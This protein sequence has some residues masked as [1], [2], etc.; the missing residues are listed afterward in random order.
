[1]PDNTLPSDRSAA[2]AVAAVVVGEAPNLFA[3]PPV[4]GPRLRRWSNIGR[5][6]ALVV[7]MLLIIGGAWLLAKP[8]KAWFVGD[9]QAKI[10]TQRVSRSDLVITVLEDGNIESASNVDIKCEVAGGSVILSI[11]PDGTLVA[12]GDK[13]VE[14]DSSTIEDQI[15]Q[16]KIVF[17]KAVAARI[18]VEK[19]L[20]AAKIAVQEYIEGT[21]VKEHQAVEAQIKIALE[22]MRSSENSLQH[23]QRLARKGYV[24]PLQLEAQRFAVDRAKLDL[25]TAQT[26]KTVLEKFTKAKMLEDLQS[27][28]D[29]AE[30]RWRAEQAAC[31]LEEQR[32]KRFQTQ[33]EKCVILA[34][35]DGMVIYANEMSGSRGSSSSQARIEEG[36]PVRERQSIIRLPDLSQMQVKVLVH[37]SKVEQLAPGQ[38]AQVKLLD[39]TFQGAVRNV[40]NQPEPSSFFSSNVKEYAAY[41][42][43]EGEVKDV[44]PGMTAEVEILIGERKNVIAV[45]VQAVVEQGRKTFCWVREAGKIER[46]PVVI[47]AS[48]SER[49]EIKDG[50]AVGDELLL[51]PRA[52]VVE[53]REDGDADEPVDVNAKFGDGK[54]TPPAE[55]VKESGPTPP[56]KN[57]AVKKVAAAM[58]SFAE[59]DKNGDKKISRDEAPERMQQSWD[60]NDTNG[61]GVIDAGEFAAMRARIQ[62]AKN[63]AAPS[64]P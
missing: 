16:Q 4:H 41:V 52:A 53:A 56:A 15:N 18:Q 63:A 59:L 57:D 34:P 47:G 24:T 19:E 22:N 9:A 8:I 44:R 29:S 33:L 36:A 2:D 64:A 61:D 55:A 38:R 49:I 6:I 28:R 54:Q 11:V 37:E 43:I 48:S 30:A 40:A 3:A 5:W 25:D 60:R 62:A 26:A 42:R 58:P 51:N 32:L 45:P 50:L 14:L 27:K 1:M 10:L 12:K 31:D 39:R 35:Q 13:I 46:R 20:S 7:V 17:E 21:F 23:T